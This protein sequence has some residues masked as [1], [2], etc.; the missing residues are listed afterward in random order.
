MKKIIVLSFSP[1]F[2]SAR[3]RASLLLHLS[4]RLAVVAHPHPHQHPRADAQRGRALP[5]THP[6]AARERDDEQRRGARPQ[7]PGGGRGSSSSSLLLLLLLLL[8]SGGGICLGR[9][10]LERVPRRCRRSRCGP[11]RVL[12]RKV[13]LDL[14]GGPDDDLL[15]V[16]VD[17]DPVFESMKRDEVSSFLSSS[18]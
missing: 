9:R 5:G 12:I 18:F 4:L 8:L 1:S 13:L 17:D 6:H 14:L 3:K 11:L 15:A 7:A 16:A 2:F 10:R